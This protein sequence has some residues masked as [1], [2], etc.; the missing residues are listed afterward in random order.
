M[1][2][3]NN[4]RNKARKSETTPLK[5]CIDE[6]LDSYKIKRK[7][8]ETQVIAS[9]EKIMGNTIAKRT[10]TVYIREKSIFVKLSSAPLKHELSMSK[11]KIIKLL[12]DDLGENFLEAIVFI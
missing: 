6:L 10:V 2:L 8:N 11:D 1:S 7:L 12:N 3:K 9:W 4:F 5:E